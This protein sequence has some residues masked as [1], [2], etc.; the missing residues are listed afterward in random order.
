MTT[1]VALATESVKEAGSF[2][3]NMINGPLALMTDDLVEPGLLVGTAFTAF[4]AGVV[5]GS[6]FAR[7]RAAE[8]KGPIMGF[9]L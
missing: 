4:G 9:V 8:G 6:I 2:V 5:T 7:K 1:R 3:S